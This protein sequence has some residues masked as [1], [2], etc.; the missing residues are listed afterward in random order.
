[1]ANDAN[2]SALDP[3]FLVANC[4][5][6]SEELIYVAL[7]R[8]MKTNES[9]ALSIAISSVMHRKSVLAQA[10]FFAIND[11]LQPTIGGLIPADEQE[12][13]L[14]NAEQRLRRLWAHHGFS[15]ANRASVRN[16]SRRVGL[17]TT[18]DYVYHLTSN[19]VHFNP[20]HLFKMGWGPIQG[21]FTFSVRH[22]SRYYLYLARFLGAMLFLG[23]SFLFSERL[24][25]DIVKTFIKTVTSTLESGVRWPEIITFEEMN[26]EPPREYSGTRSDVRPKAGGPQIVSQYPEGTE[27]TIQR[28]MIHA[29]DDVE[30]F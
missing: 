20:T 4:R 13:E 16:L 8:S 11:S 18:Y 6:I 14:S 26:R 28:R 27:V 24:G 21:P 5:S 22:F 25:P 17:K 1:M 12:R 29:K 23:Y 19:Y 2:V 7:L 10:R 15:G 30:L 9:N 3:F